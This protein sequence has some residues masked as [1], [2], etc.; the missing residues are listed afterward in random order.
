M[1]DKLEKLDRLI[2]ATELQRW[3]AAYMNDQAEVCWEIDDRLNDLRAAR[4]EL[5]QKGGEL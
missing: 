4:A 3:K 2:A 5:V 1:N